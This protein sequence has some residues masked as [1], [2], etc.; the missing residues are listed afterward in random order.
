MPKYLPI[1]AIRSMTY[2]ELERWWEVDFDVLS[3]TAVA[4]ATGAV[5]PT[6]TEAL[7]SEDWLEQWADA[8]WAAAG[9]LASA[10]E[11]ME[12][13]GDTRL[14]GNKERH[15]LV[16]SRLMYA[17]GLLKEH[18]QEQGWRM[19]PEHQKD[20]SQ[21]VLSILSRHY[22]A[23]FSALATQ[24][25]ARQGLP[26][27]NPYFGISY[28]DKYDAVEDAV[29]RGLL[30]APVT[31][32]ITSFRDLSD[33]SFTH[34]VARD[35]TEQEDR[36]AELRHP[37]LLKRWKA[38]LEA[39]RDT[40]CGLLDIPPAFSVDLPK[41]GQRELDA[42]SPAEALRLIAR[43]RFVRALAQR[44][45]EC[46]LRTRESVR[47]AAQRKQEAEQ[48]WTGAIAIARKELGRRHA[49]ERDALL[50]GLLPFCEPGSTM[51][52]RE[53]LRQTGPVPN[54]VIPMLKRALADGT[55]RNLLETP[56]A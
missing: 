2:T 7:R 49:E 4:E 9:Q 24:E 51:I 47:T 27:Q 20:A 41:L 40:H 33:D 22:S 32:K 23:E 39:L 44:N 11:R 43:R 18:K 52:R 8:L 31:P 42:V 29:S 54:Q 12:Y 16:V 36:C 48:P 56:A 10:C 28:T 55:W 26:P 37:L 6:V 17:N 3:S 35:V 45:R 30:H 15:K 25:I 13:Q 1:H 46:A 50:Q 19:L 38:S 53:D 5:H 34:I 21:A 14:K